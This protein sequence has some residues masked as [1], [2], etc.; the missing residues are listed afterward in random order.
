MCLRKLDDMEN[1]FVA[2][3]RASSM[4]VG[5]QGGGRNPLVVLNFALFCYETGRLA[6]ATE[7]YNRFMSQAQDLL[8]PTEVSRL[9]FQHSQWMYA[10]AHE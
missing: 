6:M 4:A 10:A 5:P 8:L 2:L 1:A 7:Q 9:R 3:E